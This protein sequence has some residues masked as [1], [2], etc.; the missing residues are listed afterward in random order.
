[1][2]GLI[3][4]GYGTR[5]TVRLFVFE[6]NSK[7]LAWEYQ[8]NLETGGG[9][10]Y[11]CG[12][13]VDIHGDTIM[14]GCPDETIWHSDIMGPIGAVYVFTR[15]AKT[16]NWTKHSRIAPHGVY[17]GSS[18]KITRFFEAYG[19]GQE[20]SLQGDAAVISAFNSESRLFGSDDTAAYLF[21]RDQNGNWRQQ[22][23]LLPDRKIR[24]WGTSV[25]THHGAVSQPYVVI[26]DNSVP[27]E[28]GRAPRSGFYIFDLASPPQ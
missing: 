3:E 28:T 11:G 5:S 23:R 6:R 1:V 19:F 4:G 17:R 10:G 2:G 14:A 24:G 7:T 16:G 13:A 26:G 8:T 12:G 15:D 18:D 21:R 25:S 27:P 9:D 20:I 22:A